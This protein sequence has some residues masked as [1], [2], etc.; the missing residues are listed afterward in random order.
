MTIPPFYRALNVSELFTPSWKQVLKILY[1]KNLKG[2]LPYNR[3]AWFPYKRLCRKDRFLPRIRS[4]PD[5]HMETH[6]DAIQTIHAT[7]TT[8]NNG[9]SLFSSTHRSYHEVAQDLDYFN[10]R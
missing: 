6:F 9:M 5:D 4:V 2:W 8:G 1:L 10:C 7:E 3:K